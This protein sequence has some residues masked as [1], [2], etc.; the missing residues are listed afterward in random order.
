MQSFVDKWQSKGNKWMAKF[1]KQVYT[2]GITMRI[3]DKMATAINDL[4]LNNRITTTAL[5]R[6]W[7]VDRLNKENPG[8]SKEVN[9]RL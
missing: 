2:H 4:A 9:N 6:S 5:C 1:R 7:L 8:W 3:D